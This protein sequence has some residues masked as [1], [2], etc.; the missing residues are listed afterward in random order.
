MHYVLSDIHNDNKSFCKM[1]KKIHFTDRDHLF[2][3]ADWGACA[4]KQRRRF[5]LSKIRALVKEV[6]NVEYIDSN[7]YKIFLEKSR[8]PLSD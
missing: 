4:W 7:D 5:T 6:Q 2:I 3:M 1:L 8:I